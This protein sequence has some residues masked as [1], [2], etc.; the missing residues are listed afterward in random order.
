MNFS[1]NPNSKRFFLVVAVILV[2]QLPAIFFII[3][4]FNHQVDKLP[5]YGNKEMAS[6][7]DTIY[8]KLPDFHFVTQENKP[9][10]LDSLAGKIHIA[11]FFFTTCP[12]I[13]PK[14]T[15]NLEKVHAF[16]NTVSAVHIVSYSIDP[17][18]DSIPVLAAYAKKH[19]AN[20]AKWSF[21]W[22]NQDSIYALATKGYLVTAEQGN[23]PE[24]GFLHSQKVVLIDKEFRIRG[25]YD[26]LNPAELERMIAEIKLLMAEYKDLP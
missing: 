11:D 14:L 23:G 1:S 2:L 18:H 3:S 5:I 17:K 19:R 24:N 8:H 10:S 13:C 9:I 25:F 7:G 22:G 21:V 26:G 15:K 12:G 16:V 4:K 6:N 20:P